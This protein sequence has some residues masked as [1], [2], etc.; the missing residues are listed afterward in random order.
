LIQVPLP[1]KYEDWLGLHLNLKRVRM[2]ACYIMA[3]AIGAANSNDNLDA[4]WF[5][6]MEDTPEEA[7]L[8]RSLT[9]SRRALSR[10]L[11]HG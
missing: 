2:Q 1:E 7:D 8:L 5:A 10:A 3:A 11:S 9:N 6:A 4:G